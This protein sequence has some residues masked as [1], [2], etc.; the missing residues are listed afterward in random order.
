M[1]AFPF[2]LI[3]CRGNVVHEHCA[4]IRE[5]FFKYLFLRFFC[6]FEFFL[7]LFFEF[8]FQFLCFLCFFSFFFFFFHFLS[9]VQNF[10]FHSG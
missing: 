3:C 8:F 5:T 1:V 6:F 2:Q 9:F 10:E 4:Y 7:N